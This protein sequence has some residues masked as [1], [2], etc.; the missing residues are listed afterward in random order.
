[1]TAGFLLLPVQQ[2]TFGVVNTIAAIPFI[3]TLPHIHTLYHYTLFTL[4]L[5]YY[6]YN[7][8]VSVFLIPGPTHFLI[9]SLKA[10]PI[11]KNRSIEI[12]SAPHN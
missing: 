1:M 12:L 8:Y 6:V 9:S 11:S 10:F 4:H 3:F 2:F 7:M 5:I